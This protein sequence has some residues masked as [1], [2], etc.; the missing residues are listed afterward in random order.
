MYGFCRLVLVVHSREY[1]G[2]VQWMSLALASNRK[3]IQPQN[4][5]PWSVLGEMVLNRCIERRLKEN[6]L[7]QV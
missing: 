5:A 3:G 2:E 4:S 6:W 7:N 1:L